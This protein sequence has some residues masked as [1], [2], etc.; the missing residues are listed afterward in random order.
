ATTAATHDHR[1][2]VMV[3]SWHGDGPVRLVKQYQVRSNEVVFSLDA[4]E[5]VTVRRSE[6]DV[7]E[8]SIVDLETGRTRLTLSDRDEQTDIQS[9][10]FGP[11]GRYLITSGGGGPQL[12]WK[13]RS[14]VWD[15]SG[16]KARQVGTFFTDP[17]LSPDGRFLAVR[18]ETQVTLK[19]L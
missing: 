7:A 13:T 5:F 11:D 12:D 8:I 15:I 2:R 4:T 10:A 3:W 18:E 9:V 6:R 19:E 14:V 16:R 1:D 17:V